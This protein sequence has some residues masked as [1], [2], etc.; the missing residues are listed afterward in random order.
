MKKYFKIL[1]LVAMSFA[2]AAA[3]RVG[4]RKFAPGLY[5]SI[6]YT[7]EQRAVASQPVAEPAKE[8][9]IP[10]TPK[11]SLFDPASEP[12]KKAAPINPVFTEELEVRGYAKRGD[13]LAWNVV[14]SD[15][16][17][18]TEQDAELS[19]VGRK[20]VV[21][22]GKKYA[23]KNPPP[24]AQP[25]LDSGRGLA[26]TR[27]LGGLSV[28]SEATGR[29]REA[30]TSPP[31]ET[32]Q[33]DLPPVA[34]NSAVLPVSKRPEPLLRPSIMSEFDSLPPRSGAPKV[35]TKRFMP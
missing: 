26:L 10:E 11:K 35:S 14:L 1:A 4:L 31:E 15:G 27:G 7:P 13:E 6:W 30:K 3:L 25:G 5:G 23:F 33:P 9:E 24:P 16:S 19:F 2:G 12:A 8:A 20:H 18:L 29:S 32:H 28:P 21:I 17:V 34:S 22:N